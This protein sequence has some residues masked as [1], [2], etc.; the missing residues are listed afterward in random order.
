VLAL[1][2]SG[3]DLDAIAGEDRHSYAKWY[4]RA[5]SLR[6]QIRELREFSRQRRLSPAPGIV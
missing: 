2:R 4:M 5:R 3:V 6:E 1:I